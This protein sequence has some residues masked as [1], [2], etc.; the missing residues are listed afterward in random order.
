MV[1]EPFVRFVGAAKRQRRELTKTKFLR[2]T[3]GVFLFDEIEEALTPA[4]GNL[5]MDPPV[6]SRPEYRELT[7]EQKE[8][9]KG[10]KVYI[11]KQ[12]V[13]HWYESTQNSARLITIWAIN[14][15]DVL[16]GPFGPV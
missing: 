1:E 11:G 14:K 3:E 12:F 5:V 8:R 15:V 10:T 2:R 16:Y 7:E 9:A 13:L 4:V 6:Q